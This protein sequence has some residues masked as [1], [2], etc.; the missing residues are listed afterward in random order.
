MLALLMLGNS[1]EHFFGVANY[2]VML[3]IS[4][5]GGNL[6]SAALGDKCGIA[7]GASTSIMGILAFQVVWF[8]TVWN[9]LGTLKYIYALY[10]GIITSTMLFAGFYE[11]G[12]D[13]DSWGHIGGFSVGL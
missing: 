9:H 2:F 11:T 8:V 13:I 10:L 4:G 1:A 5:I 3:L 7:V 12:G 6:F